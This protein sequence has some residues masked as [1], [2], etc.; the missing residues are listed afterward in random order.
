MPPPCATA[1]TPRKPD[2]AM[3]I[4]NAKRLQI[5]EATG[6]EVGTDSSQQSVESKVVEFSGMQLR[7]NPAQPAILTE[8]DIMT[9]ESVTDP[10]NPKASQIVLTLTPEA[11]ER[12]LI[13]TT[14]LSSQ[15]NPGYLVIEFD[16]TILSAP[17]VN[18]KISSKVAI[19]FAERDKLNMERVVSAVRE[20]IASRKKVAKKV[21]DARSVVEAYVASALAGD[22]AKAA[23]LAKNSPA[24][25]KHI[26]RTSRVSQCP[27]I[28]DRNGLRQRSGETDASLGNFGSS[29]A[30]RRTQATRRPTRWL[31]GVHA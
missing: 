31:H 30:R 29:Q 6:V 9:V 1:M 11:G 18:D 23:A 15:P 4:L 2:Q 27:A 24:D 22:V 20:S 21:P 8:D 17:R 25:P 7:L 10:N 26:Q 13:E 16:G 19:S 12:F 5:R 14:R 28:E 3:N